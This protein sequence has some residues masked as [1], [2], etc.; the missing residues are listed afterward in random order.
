MK[1]SKNRKQARIRLCGIMALA[2]DHV[3]KVSGGADVYTCRKICDTFEV[4]VHATG[5]TDRITIN[6][7]TTT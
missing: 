1:H 7:T 5:N 4:I 3:A 2:P 6:K